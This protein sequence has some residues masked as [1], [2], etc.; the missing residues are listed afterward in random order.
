MAKVTREKE[1]NVSAEALADVILD[2]EGYPKILGEVKAAKPK[3]VTPKKHCKVV[4]ELEI[5]KK[6]SYELNFDVD[7]PNRVKYLFAF[8]YL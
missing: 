8:S 3:W 1:M 7:Y 4:F 2:F 6:F 5:V